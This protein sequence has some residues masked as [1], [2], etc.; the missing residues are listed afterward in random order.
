[1]KLTLI[2][3]FRASIFIYK[4]WEWKKYGEGLPPLDSSLTIFLDFGLNRYPV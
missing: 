4:N 1:M 3:F 2:E